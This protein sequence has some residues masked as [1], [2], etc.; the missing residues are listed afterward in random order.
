VFPFL[1]HEKYGGAVVDRQAY[2]DVF[3]SRVSDCR[4]SALGP[5]MVRFQ[6]METAI[7]RNKYERALLG[8][9]ARLL[10]PSLYKKVYGKEY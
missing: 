8:P 3:T 5:R 10:L 7:D 9:F 4:S 6:P 1:F 2:R